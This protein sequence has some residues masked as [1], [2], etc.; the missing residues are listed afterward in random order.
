VAGGLTV[1]S[2]REGDEQQ[3]ARLFNAYTAA[4]VGPFR[5][6]PES[7]LA[8]CRP[9][10]RGAGLEVDP[11]CVRVAERDG[12]IL[13]YTVADHQPTTGISSLY[14]LCVAEAAEAETLA[15]ALLDDVEKIARRR[16]RSA[17]LLALAGDDGAALHAGQAAGY[18]FSPGASVFMTSLLD[19]GR[20]LA[21]L[22]PAL[23][24]RLAGSTLRDWRGEIAFAS[25]E[26]GANVSVHDGRVAVI[27]DCGPPTVL[28]SVAPAALPRLLLGQV[29]VGECYVQNELSVTAADRAEALRLLDILFP[30]LPAFLPRAQWW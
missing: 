4:F 17:L 14:E 2:Y 6:T 5:V 25:G 10:W 18:E 8:Q 3:V 16:G 28:A 26:R 1:R 20:F 24:H 19:L 7:W 23:E 13:G 11:E 22:R 30:R 27:A 15:E 12:R 21:E 29:S 9:S